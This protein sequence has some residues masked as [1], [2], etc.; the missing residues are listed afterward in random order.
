MNPELFSEEYKS[1]KFLKC[2][3]DDLR[4]YKYTETLLNNIRPPDRVD[5]KTFVWQKRIEFI[6]QLFDLVGSDVWFVDMNGTLRK[7]GMHEYDYD[8]AKLIEIRECVIYRGFPQK[9][10]RYITY[11]DLQKI[12]DPRPGLVIPS[13]SY[14]NT[15]NR[16]YVCSKAYYMNI[17]I[18]AEL[19]T[20]NP[21]DPMVCYGL[22]GL[23]LFPGAFPTYNAMFYDKEWAELYQ[24]SVTS[25]LRK[26]NDAISAISRLF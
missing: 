22:F 6:E 26:N 3:A 25:F 7:T 23:P 10:G 2:S 18:E 12:S 9:P 1:F 11:E 16:V 19:R 14:D 8:T 13:N 17:G 24:K 15:E 5:D 4:Y 20:V 21:L